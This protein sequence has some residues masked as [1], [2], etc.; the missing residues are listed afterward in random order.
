MSTSCTFD[1]CARPHYAKG[2]CNPHWQRVRRGV[3]LGP[4][5]GTPEAFW[6]LAENGGP[7]ECW[8]W[9]GRVDH[10]G[11]GLYGSPLLGEGRAHRRAWVLAHGPIPEGLLVCHHCDNPPCVNPA[12]LFL[13][14]SADNTRDSVEKGRRACGE[15][16]NTA[17]LSVADVREIRRLREGGA[18]QQALADRFGCSQPMVGVIVRREAWRHV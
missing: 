4:L 8:E 17:K 12:H 18:T 16:V 1:A 14:T 5:R 6:A 15:R 7:G 9:Q 2:L 3:P 10:D 11:Y 13:G